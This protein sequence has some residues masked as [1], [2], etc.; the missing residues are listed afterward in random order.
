M[1]VERPCPEDT[2]FPLTSS[3][4][5]SLLEETGE[6]DAL[7]L[8]SQFD[9]LAVTTLTRF[10]E[11]GV[12]GEMVWRIEK[13]DGLRLRQVLNTVIVGGSQVVSYQ[14]WDGGRDTYTRTSGAWMLGRDMDPRYEDPFLEVARLA[15]ENPDS[16]WPPFRFDVSQFAGLSWTITGDALDSYQIARATNVTHEV[17][18]ELHGLPPQIVGISIYSGGLGQEDVT[19]TMS[20]STDNWDRG[21][22][23]DYYAEYLEGERYL[24]ANGLN[25]F[26]RA[27]VPFIPVPEY[28]TVSGDTTTVS[29]TVPAEMTHEASLFEIEM[30]VFSGGSSIAS[31]VLSEG[32]TNSSSEGGGWWALSWDDAS[33]PGLLSQ[34]DSYSVSTN[35]DA[36]FEIRVFDKWAQAW[37]DHID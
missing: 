5:N 19:F 26:P 1:E 32:S 7:E 8:S 2:C 25:S 9:T 37:T 10:T 23:T 22:D 34:L 15:T 4:F 21:L 24:E 13:D 3:A 18:F 16:R 11:S 20:I 35:S 17:Y 31:L 14:I 29:G 6:L 28:Q 36:S 12:E 33:G 30:H 27:P